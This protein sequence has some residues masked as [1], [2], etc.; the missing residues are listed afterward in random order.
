V[1][2][3]GSFECWDGSL[4]CTEADCPSEPLGDNNLTFQNVDLEAG[5]FDIYMT[6]EDAVGGFQA[7]FTRLILTGGSGGSAEEAGFMV[8]AGGDQILGFSL[9]GASISAGEGVL[10]TVTFDN[11][12]IIPEEICF[13]TVTISDPFGGQLDFDLGDCYTGDDAGDDGGD[14]GG[15]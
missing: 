7:Q 4:A 14:D 10:T 12:T 3:Y 13:G 6:N 9:T 1:F 11:T 2:E 15:G 5:V 8:S